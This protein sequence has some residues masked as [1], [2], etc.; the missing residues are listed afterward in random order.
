MQ[1]ERADVNEEKM[2]ERGRAQGKRK[3][4]DLMS[5]LNSSSASRDVHI[6]SDR[7]QSILPRWHKMLEGV[8]D[9]FTEGHRRELKKAETLAGDRMAQPDEEFILDFFPSLA[10]GP[11]EEGKT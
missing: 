1:K 5:Y 6:S 11:H 7:W 9:T 8:K 3:V 2:L 4:W 10:G